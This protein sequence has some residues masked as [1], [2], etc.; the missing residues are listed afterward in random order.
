VNDNEG[1]RLV[2]TR[3]AKYAITPHTLDQVAPGQVVLVALRVAA[4]LAGPGKGLA[5]HCLCRLFS[6]PRGEELYVCGDV[7]VARADLV[8]V[9][10]EED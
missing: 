6:R 9:Y 2:R 4:H 10:S 1:M 5:T 8:P 3:K 7:N